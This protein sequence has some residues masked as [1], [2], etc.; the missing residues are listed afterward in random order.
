MSD[1]KIRLA[2]NLI[3]ELYHD[4]DL[5]YH[6]FNDL[7]EDGYSLLINDFIPS[8][9]RE[10]GNKGEYHT[11]SLSDFIEE[12]V[13]HSRIKNA[14]YCFIQ[15]SFQNEIRIHSI[16][17]TGDIV[18][19]CE[20]HESITGLVI[21]DL[22]YCGLNKDDHSII[23]SNFRGFITRY[24][25]L[26]DNDV[27]SYTLYEEKTCNLDCPHLFEID[28]CSGF[29][30]YESDSARLLDILS[31]CISFEKITMKENLKKHLSESDYSKLIMRDLAI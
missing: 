19:D 3:L 17:V 22:D 6:Y 31:N 23:E 1:T 4:S 2:E 7:F 30:G 9:K 12:N 24:N 5:A 21:L 28:S 13:F 18:P 16:V 20:V 29:Y 11:H 10:Y 15:G 8:L 25:A 27:V 26:L 14:A